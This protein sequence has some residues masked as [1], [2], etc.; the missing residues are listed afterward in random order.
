MDFTAI[1]RSANVGS[2]IGTYFGSIPFND[3]VAGRLTESRFSAQ[4]SRISLKVNGKL[5][6][7]DITG[8]I[9]SDFPWFPAHKW[10]GHQ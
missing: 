8:Y 7:N 5:G 10:I 3:T 4:N 1:F 9:E 2:G 6:A